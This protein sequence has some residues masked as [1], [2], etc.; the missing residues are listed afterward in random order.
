MTCTAW[1]NGM[2][3]RKWRETKQQLMWLPDLALLGYCLASLPFLC[4]IPFGHAVLSNLWCV[5]YNAA[6]QLQQ[7]SGDNYKLIKS[8]LITQSPSPYLKAEKVRLL[9]RIPISL[10]ATVAGTKWGGGNTSS[11]L[12]IKSNNKSKIKINWRWRLLQSTNL[13]TRSEWGTDDWGFVVYIT[14]P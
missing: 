5:W 3:H 12:H 8:L 10:F 4:D 13:Q 6:C 1:P 7:F 11:I 2:S 14:T 9:R